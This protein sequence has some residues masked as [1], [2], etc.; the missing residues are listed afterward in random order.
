MPPVT[1]AHGRHHT[2]VVLLH[3]YTFF[4]GLILT[5]NLL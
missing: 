3:A 4:E 1:T 5:I 2:K